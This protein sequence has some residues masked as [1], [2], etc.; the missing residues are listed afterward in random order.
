VGRRLRCGSRRPTWCPRRRTLLSGY[1]CFAELAEACEVFCEKVNGRVHRETARVPVEAL[2]M[3]RT[4]LHPL[5]V[6]PFT[7]R[8]G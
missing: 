5:P 7:A 8:A 3:E 4:R 1:N 2:Q 6:T